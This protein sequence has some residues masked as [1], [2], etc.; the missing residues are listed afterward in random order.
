MAPGCRL[1]RISRSTALRG[2][3]AFASFISVATFANRPANAVCQCGKTWPHLFCAHHRVLGHTPGPGD[4]SNVETGGSWLWVRSPEQERRVVMNLFNRYCIRCHG[5]DG[6][7][8]WDIPDVP[9]FTNRVWQE[10]RP[11]AYRARV[12]IEGRGAVMPSFRGVITLE[13]SHALA[14]YLHKFIPGAEESRPGLGH[15]ASEN[16]PASVRPA[17]PSAAAPSHTTTPPA[18]PVPAANSAPAP[19]AAPVSA[20]PSAVSPPSS[21][22]V[23]PQPVTPPPAPPSIAPS[24]FKG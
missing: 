20:T 4:I 15:E 10:T 17:S 16:T 7:G 24:P 9:D 12:I 3:I 19:S 2:A 13:E 11:D 8:V 5:V 21:N 23:P 1:V 22:P 14:R 18:S 6:R